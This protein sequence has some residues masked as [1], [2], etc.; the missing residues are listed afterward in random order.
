MTA[1]RGGGTIQF[2]GSLESDVVTVVTAN[3]VSQATIFGDTGLVKMRLDLKDPG[4]PGSTNVPSP[5]NSVTFT[6]YRVVY[7]RTDGRNAQ[8]VDVPYAFDSGAT[9]TVPANG[10]VSAQFDIVRTSA[11][12]EAPLLALGVN[13]DIINTIADVTFYGKDQANNSVTVT[14]SIAVTFANF[15]DSN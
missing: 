10:E 11:K 5:L 14:G 1:S 13:G 4:A 12:Q 8:G 15:S 7:R 2:A 6:H 3:N 9:F